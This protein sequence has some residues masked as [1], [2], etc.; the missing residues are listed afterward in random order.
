MGAPLHEPQCR[1]GVSPASV[2]NA[3]RPEPLALARSLGRQDACPTLGALR[4]MVPMQAQKRKE[5][6]HEPTHSSSFSFSS[7]TSHS[8]SPFH[9]PV[10]C[11][12]A[13]RQSKSWTK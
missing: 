12:Q 7:S 1:A 4:F 10:G 8:F 3:D 11:A 9:F 13:S 5:P 6:L 2:G